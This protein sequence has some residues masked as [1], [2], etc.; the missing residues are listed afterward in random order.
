MNK[1]NKFF[2]KIENLIII[3]IIFEANNKYISF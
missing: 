2:L 1:K 3:I